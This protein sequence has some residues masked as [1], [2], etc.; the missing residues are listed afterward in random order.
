[1]NKHLALLCLMS[2]SAQASQIQVMDE[3]QEIHAVMSTSE[4][5]R[6]LVERDRIS[7]VFTRSSS[8]EILPDERL[9]QIFIK[10]N[11]PP[12][13]GLRLTLT[14]EDGRIQ[15][16]RLQGQNI[17]GQTLILKERPVSHAEPKDHDECSEIVHILSEFV[18]GRIPEGF[19]LFE[20]CEDIHTYTSHSYKVE[21]FTYTN[22]SEVPLT[23]G[24]G[25]FADS[26]Q[27]VLIDCPYLEPGESTSLWRVLNND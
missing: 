1:M 15:D 21:S 6:I 13:E 23:L 17:S 27:A 11:H 5:N 25:L 12:K 22:T 26:A 8:L 10:L 4:L 14:T 16:L 20:R 24:E 7:D 9:G 18:L 19:S 3:E 2:C